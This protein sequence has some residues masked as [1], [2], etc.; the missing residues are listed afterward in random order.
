MVVYFY[1]CEGFWRGITRAAVGWAGF[2]C[3]IGVLFVG[4]RWGSVCEAMH[5]YRSYEY[6]LNACSSTRACRFILRVGQ[7]VIWG[8]YCD[9]FERYADLVFSRFGGDLLSHALRRST[10]SATALNGRVRNGA[11]C[12]A[13]AMATKPRKYQIQVKHVCV[14]AF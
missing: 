7:G 9:R 2:I 3:F 8:K 12:F 4:L 11:G 13:R 1:R 14:Y 6:D 5:V 10:I